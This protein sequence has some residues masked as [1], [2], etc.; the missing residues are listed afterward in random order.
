MAKVAF[1]GLGVM[2][3]PM[4]GHLANQGHQVTVYNRTTAKAQQWAAQYSGELALTPKLAAVEQDIVFTCVGND[5]DL[6]QV[7]LGEDGIVH[8]IKAG[9]IL[10]DHTTASADVARELAAVLA[11]QEVEFLDAPVS[12]GQAGAENGVLT[13]MMGGKEAVFNQVKPV[14]EAYSRCAELLGEVGAGQLTK[15]VN[16]ICI[17]GVVQGLAEGL[18]FAKSAGLD[19]LKVVEVISKGAAQSW[20]ME[21][22]YQ[23]MWQGE[24]DFGFAID[25][26]R[27]DLAIALDEGRRN[28]SQLPVTALV[29]QFYSEVQ[30][31]KG[32]RWDTSSLLARLEKN[33]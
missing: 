11:K 17:A 5:D 16:Q 26:M 23:T 21:N 3:Y 14:I 13:V 33:R 18:H 32:N 25:W 7:V 19:G 10:V 8:G 6:R 31:M 1:I 28:G 27:K 4:A 29:D 30:A 15:M 20:Q 2:G 9:A 22:R 24:Y 12:G